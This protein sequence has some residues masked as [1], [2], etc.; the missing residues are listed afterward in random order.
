MISSTPC[1]GWYVSWTTRPYWL[2]LYHI[3]G[4]GAA[5]CGAR[6]WR[7]RAY[8]ERAEYL[9][10]CSDAIYLAHLVVPISAFRM[11][12]RTLGF[13]NSNKLRTTAQHFIEGPA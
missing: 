2:F 4:R 1:L 12:H 8:A 7:F 13:N 3:S 9:C 11:L 6:W 10:H 5:L